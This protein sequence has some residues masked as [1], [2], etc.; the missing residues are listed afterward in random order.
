MSS[1]TPGEEESEITIS[2]SP[3]DNKHTVTLQTILYHFIIYYPL[4]SV[5]NVCLTWSHSL[6]KFIIVI[7]LCLHGWMKEKWRIFHRNWISTSFR[8]QSK[9]LIIITAD[10]WV[11]RAD[12]AVCFK[13]IINQRRD[14]QN[15]N[16]IDYWLQMWSLIYHL[17]LSGEFICK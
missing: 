10:W 8:L 1:S 11:M 12:S 14:R 13:E 6:Y 4:L 15:R 3:P 17:T 9:S 7:N 16:T 5:I 2:R